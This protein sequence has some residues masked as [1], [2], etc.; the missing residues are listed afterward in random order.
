MTFTRINTRKI[1]FASM[2]F[3]TTMVFTVAANAESVNS[4]HSGTLNIKTET[5]VQGVTLPPGEY[6]VRE[7]STA[8][9]ATVE[10][11]RKYWNEAASELV[12]AEEDQLVARVPVTEQQIEQRPAH[13]KL[14]LSADKTTATALE[15]R[16]VPV[17]YVFAGTDTANRQGA[18]AN[19]TSGM[20]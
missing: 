18:S 13:T 9:G 10:F 15:F 6:E 14:Q 4:H 2:L 19:D 3:A 17:D 16:H 5:V 12:Q 1:Q 7:A 20:Q 8:D 11:V